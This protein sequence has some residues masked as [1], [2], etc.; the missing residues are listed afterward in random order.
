MGLKTFFVATGDFI[1]VI[2]GR[3]RNK[4]HCILIPCED[5][6]PAMC[7]PDF[8]RFHQIKLKALTN[9]LPF[10]RTL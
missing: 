9:C 5:A 10:I 4:I 7:G 2:E 3:A 6:R 8:Q 1:I